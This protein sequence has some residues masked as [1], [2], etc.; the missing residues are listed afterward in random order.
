MPENCIRDSFHLQN[1]T[2][3]DQS[4]YWFLGSLLDRKVLDELS[5][6]LRWRAEYSHSLQAQV[7]LEIR[8]HSS[9]S[10]LHSL[11]TSVKSNLTIRSNDSGRGLTYT[12]ADIS[13]WKLLKQIFLLFAWLFETDW[14][15]GKFDA[16]EYSENNKVFYTYGYVKSHDD[17]LRKLSTT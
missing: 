5:K 17:K 12:D 10:I 14:T 15:S 6:Y 11:R 9:G 16:L 1:S 8:D 2:A 4:K 7:W 3:N 13:N